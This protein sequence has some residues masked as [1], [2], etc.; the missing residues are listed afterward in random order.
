MTELATPTDLGIKVQEKIHNA[1][2]DLIPPEEWNAY[3]QC[4]WKR[5][6]SEQPS[7]SSY[8]NTPEP[9]RLQLIVKE[10]VEREARKILEPL[11]IDYLKQQEFT[12]ENGD[13]QYLGNG[14][15]A[16]C[17]RA[18]IAGMVNHAQEVAR[19]TLQG[20]TPGMY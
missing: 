3:V 10:Y 16:A 5:F 17:V 19:M 12:L 13:I 8:S 11:I 18:F 15:A 7:R 1:F 9:S 6:V 4:E 14:I 2:V 20:K